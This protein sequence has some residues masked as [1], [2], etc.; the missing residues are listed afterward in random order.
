MQEGFNR[1]PN[2]PT[3]QKKKK[4]IQRKKDTP[5]YQTCEHVKVNKSKLP[6]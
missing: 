1:H 5:S 3:P 6:S 2:T 4:K